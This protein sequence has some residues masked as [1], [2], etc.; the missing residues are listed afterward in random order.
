MIGDLQAK[1]VATYDTW[2]CHNHVILCCKDTKQFGNDATKISRF[3]KKMKMADFC[4]N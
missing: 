1:E 3:Q 2:I 4:K